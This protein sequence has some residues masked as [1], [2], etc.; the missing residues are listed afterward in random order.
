M[1]LSDNSF[2]LSGAGN[3]TRSDGPETDQGE[4]ENL[5]LLENGLS[6]FLQLLRDGPG[7]ADRDSLECSEIMWQNALL[8]S[9]YLCMV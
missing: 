4:I 6:R 1:D 7:M 5:G 8:D 2:A 3:T 9:M